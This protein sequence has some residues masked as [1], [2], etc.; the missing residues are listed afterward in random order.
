MMQFVA[1][2]RDLLTLFFAIGGILVSLAFGGILR[3]RHKICLDYQSRRDV[4]ISILR[5]RFVQRASSHYSNIKNE[6]KSRKI[7]VEQIYATPGQREL[8]EGLAKDLADQNRIKSLFK[9][10]SNFSV[11]AFVLNWSMI[12]II[13]LGVLFKYFGVPVWCLTVCMTLFLISLLGFVLAVS[14]MIL[15]DA[16]FFQFVHKI[17]E[18][19]GE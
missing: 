19:E 15:F 14:V 5:D 8:V 9:W 12:V 3:W 2:N 13:I 11:W 7:T 10:L 18:E 6:I 16:Q 4:A 17:I 1:D